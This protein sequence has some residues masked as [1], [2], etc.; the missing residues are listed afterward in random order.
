MVISIGLTLFAIG[1]ILAQFL[2]VRYEWETPKTFELVA[3]IF[4]LAG[5]VV[6][7]IGAVIWAW[8]NLL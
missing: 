1:Y 7:L 6:F 5:I 2:S 3:S 4:V 8:E